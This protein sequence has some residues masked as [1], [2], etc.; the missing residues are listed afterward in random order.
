MKKRIFIFALLTVLVLT[1][2]MVY[3]E[4]G[5]EKIYDKYNLKDVDKLPEGVVPIVIDSPKEL[6]D[7]LKSIDNITLD[8]KSIETT[9]S[10]SENPTINSGY[11][12]TVTKTTSA[13]AGTFSKVYLKAYIDVYNSGSFRQIVGCSESTYLSGTSLGLDWVENNTGHNIMNDGRKI[14]VYGDGVLETY[15]IIEG[16]IKVNSRPISLSLSYSVY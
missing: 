1:N 6:E 5:N 8:E 14:N 12:A 16:G 4:I 7:C 3:A 11:T 9:V 10:I 2:T 13:T 15:L